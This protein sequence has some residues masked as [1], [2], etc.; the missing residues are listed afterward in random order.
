VVTEGGVG[1]LQIEAA[2]RNLVVDRLSASVAGWFAAAGI[3]CMLIKGP[4]IADW[5]YPDVVRSYADSDLL[6]ARPD[7]ERAIAVLVE[8]GFRDT[9]G[10]M[11]HPRM[12]SLA[13]TSFVRGQEH[14]DLHCT[15]AGLDAAPEEVW[16]VLRA[17]ADEQR[18]G[19][20]RLAV[21][22]RA[23]T[24]MHLALH[25]AHHGGLHK[26]AEDLRRGLTAAGAE[27]WRE[28]AELAARL[29]GVPAFAS[30]LRHSEQGAELARQLDL[31]QVGSVR[32]DLRAS[33]VP[34]AEGLNEL[35]RPDLSWSERVALVSAE[36]FPKPS[37]MRWW[38]PLA[39]RGPLGLAAAYARRWIWL[40]VKL[41]AG[42]AEL[43]R[44]RRLRRT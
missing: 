13:G 27:T 36:L 25:A 41:P 32:L 24:L 37:F 7:W 29:D 11:G 35:L 3:D 33:G 38:T 20:R 10:P 6:V 22:S 18:V 2:V 21:P 9:L 15:L 12:E 44:V 34:I 4:V 40:A 5:L 28:A 1:Q 16:R 39:D 31:D 17:G 14:V 26:P 8:N 23:A 19:G 42:V 30:G 43:R